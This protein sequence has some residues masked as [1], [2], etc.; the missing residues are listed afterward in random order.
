MIKLITKEFIKR[1]N[2]VHN[3]FYDYKGSVYIGSDKKIE[4]VCLNHGSFS[5]EASSH[6]RG[7]RCKECFDKTMKSNP[8][9]FIKKAMLYIIIFMIIV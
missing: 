9:D 2:I 7:T 8:G 3:N 1:S 4:I 6:L 5:V